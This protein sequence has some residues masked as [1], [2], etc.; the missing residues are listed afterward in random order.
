MLGP[1]DFTGYQKDSQTTFLYAGARY[2]MA[3]LGRFGVT[4]Q[5]ADK[6][7]TLSPY[8]YAANN[9]ALIVDINGDSLII[10]EGTAFGNP[11][12]VRALHRF[13]DALIAEMDARSEEDVNNG[14]FIIRVT[15]GDRHK[16]S[17]DDKTVYSSSDGGV[18]KNSDTGSRH[19][20][21]NG[22]LAADV[23]LNRDQIP[24]DAVTAA[25][26]E[27][28]LEKSLRE[29]EPQHYHLA[30]PHSKIVGLFFQI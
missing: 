29:S 25:A 18:I 14:D 3:A 30:P 2:Y 1:E 5:F 20:E 22:G 7:P 8:Q 24:H 23:F 13:N 17:G 9:P 12:T 26:G 19:L 21:E 11:E 28:G 27:A 4:D 10:P 15:G 6:E 16:K